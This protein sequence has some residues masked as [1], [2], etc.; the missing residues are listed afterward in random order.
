MVGSGLVDYN[1][2]NNIDE[3][4]NSLSA[5]ASGDTGVMD[6]LYTRD[7]NLTLDAEGNLLTSE[8]RRVMGYAVTDGTQTTSIDPTTGKIL[9]V[10]ADAVDTTT[11]KSKLAIVGANGTDIKLVPL[12]IPDTVYA[13]STDTTGQAVKTFE[14][15]KD[16]LIT[17]VL[18]DGTRAAMGQIALA[19]FKNPEG[20]NSVG[21]NLLQKTSNA[22]TEIIK[23]G[24]GTDS[25]KD[26]RNGFGDFIQGA[27]EGSNVD[28][29]EQFTDMITATRSFQAASKMIT[30]GDE[31]LQTITGLMR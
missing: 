6:I 9:N 13:D 10:N 27:L 3:T 4:T 22:G 24:L 18:G 7:G 14:I 28:L 12:K 23:N 19:S 2:G 31:I 20:L 26:N 11:G 25:T 30:T 29:T 1:G 15:G 8:G 21:G 17:A 5:A 16:G